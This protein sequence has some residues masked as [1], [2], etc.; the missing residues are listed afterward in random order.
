MS[1]SL[2]VLVTKKLIEQA[3]RRFWINVVGQ[4][5]ITK[6]VIACVVLLLGILFIE[7][8]WIKA[9]CALVVLMFPCVGFLGYFSIL[10]RA[11]SRLE[12]MDSKQ[13]TFQFT[14]QGL[15][16]RSDLGNGEIPWKMVDKIQRYPDVWLIYVGSRDYLYLPAAQMS[17]EMQTFIMEQAAKHSLTAK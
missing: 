11:C 14:E 13:I 8:V 17:S 6:L 12:R 1:Y 5:G 3:T 7:E 9:L 16:S 4:G 15:S 2:D 10:R